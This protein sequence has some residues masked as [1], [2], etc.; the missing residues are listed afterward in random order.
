ML[1]LDL[2]RSARWVD[3]GLGVRIEVLPITTHA[4][5][6]ARRDRAFLEA[7]RKFS[8]EELSDE[9][10][11]DKL[12]ETEQ[13]DEL[14]IAM[15]KALG[16]KVIVGW[17]GVGDADGEPVAVTPEGIDALLDL[18]PMFDAFQKQVLQAGLVLESEKNVSALSPSGTSAGAKNTAPRA[19]ASAKSARRK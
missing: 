12:L 17:D 7:A 13:G 10:V 15:S 6:A 16:R 1:R 8:P 3:L 2:N 5:S 11:R 19:R 9:A 14:A 18:W 4:M